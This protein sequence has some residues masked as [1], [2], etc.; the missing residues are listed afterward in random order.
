[1]ARTLRPLSLGQILDET[2]SI[3]RKNFVLFITISAI[4]NLIV[5]ILKFGMGWAL[6][7]NSI[8][9][10]VLGGL[11]TGLALIFVSSLV[12]AATTIGVSDVYLEVPT[13]ASACFARVTDRVPRV[14]LVSFLFGLAVGIGFLLLV[15]PGFYVAGLYG[16][17]VPALVLEDIG[18][19]DALTRSS[20]LAKGAVGRVIVVFILTTILVAILSGT[21][22]VVASLLGRAVFQQH[23]AQAAWEEVYSTISTILFGPVSA[24][25]L[26]LIYYDQRI[27]REAFDISHMMGLMNRP[28]LAAQNQELAQS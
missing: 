15:I 16:L 8:V 6:A 19:F 5:L 17:A 21:L 12:T 26:T 18:A 28:D 24:I 14:L 13:T 25:A 1:M 27:R 2:F 9:L 11:A 7:N 4:P 3:Y 22:D 10:G 20:T 23:Y